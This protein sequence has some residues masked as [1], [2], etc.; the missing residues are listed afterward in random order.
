MTK[1]KALNCNT[2]YISSSGIEYPEPPVEK[3]LNRNNPYS[4]R[5]KATRTR[6]G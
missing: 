1:V 3:Q 5:Q 6:L 2:E 4:Q